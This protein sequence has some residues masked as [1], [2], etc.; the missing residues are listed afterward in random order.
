[1]PAVVPAAV[2]ANVLA[3]VP[4]AVPP[5]VPAMSTHLADHMVDLAQPRKL[6]HLMISSKTKQAREIPLV[7][8]NQQKKE[9]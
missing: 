3:A 8:L 6:C 1:M 7:Y 9:S 5:A 4:V 2:P